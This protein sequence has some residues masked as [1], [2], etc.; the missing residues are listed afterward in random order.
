MKNSVSFSEPQEFYGP[1]NDEA[2]EA[3]GLRELCGNEGIAERKTNWNWR[4][5]GGIPA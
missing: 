2:W 1:S 4:L 3:G 5:G